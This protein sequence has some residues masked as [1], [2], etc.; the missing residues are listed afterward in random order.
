M[1]LTSPAANTPGM[2]VLVPPCVTIYP[3]ASRSICPLNSAVFRLWPMAMNT[4]QGRS[5]FHPGLQVA[6]DDAGP[7]LCQ[8]GDVITSESQTN[9]ILG[10]ANAL[11]CMIFDARSVSRRDDGHLRRE[12]SSGRSLPPSPSRRRRPRQSACAEECRRTA[13][14]WRRRGPTACDPIDVEPASGR[15]GRDNQRRGR[16]APAVLQAQSEGRL[17]RSTL[18]TFPCIT[19]YRSVPLDAHLGHQIG[20]M[21]PSRNPGQFSTWSS[22]SAAHR[23]RVP[24]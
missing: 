4:R 3:V 21:M 18:A 9:S 19:R 17:R 5:G 20:P 24:R 13:H 16:D 23:P 8:I 6:H 2:F 22:A 15:S 12:P 14:T 11:S 7:H 1:V 10:L